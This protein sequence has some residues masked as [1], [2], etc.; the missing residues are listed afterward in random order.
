MTYAVGIVGATG[1]VGNRIRECLDK[2]DFPVDHARSRFFASERS[3]GIE[4]QWGKTWITYEYATSAEDFEGLDIVFLSA[5]GDA[6]KSRVS[7]ELCPLVAQAGAIAIDNSSAWRMH[8]DVPL[9]VTEVNPEKLAERPLGI[10]ANPNCTTMIAA[11]ILSALHNVA[12]LESVNATTY[13][14]VSGQGLAGVKE[15]MHQIE[16]MKGDALGII[17]GVADPALWTAPEVFPGRVGF[18]VFPFAGEFNELGFGTSEEAKFKRETRKILDLPGLPVSATCV[19]VPVLNGHSMALSI[20]CSQ[21]L[22]PREAMEILRDAP[23]VELCDVP[24]P[25]SASGKDD[26]LVGRVRQDPTRVNGIELFIS[27]DNL[28][29]GAALNAVQIAERLLQDS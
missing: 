9:V 11:P 27:G 25:L 21:E 28:L 23:G 29:K 1:L 16:E 10:V 15:A 4:S 26:V 19:R 18:N 6:T 2:R 14:S 20:G 12:G 8:P 5:G 7:E 24:T 17:E 3:V 13:Q 22:R